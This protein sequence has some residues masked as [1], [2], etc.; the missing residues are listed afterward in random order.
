MKPVKIVFATD[1]SATSRRAL[2]VAREL[3]DRFDGELEVVHV[4]DPES[5]EVPLPYGMMPGAATWIDDHFAK[6]RDRGRQ[7]LTDLLPE[8]GE[9]SSHFLEGRPGPEIVR[10]AHDHEADFLVMGTHGYKG[11]QRMLMGSVAEYILRHADCPVLTVK[12]N[13]D[14]E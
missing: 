5:F 3:R 7:A 4:Y 9:C 11:F 10:F 1:F 12:D 13:P 6:M 8:I 2:E 14:T